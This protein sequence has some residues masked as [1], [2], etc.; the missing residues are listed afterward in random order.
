MTLPPNIEIT[1]YYYKEHVEEIS[2]ELEQAQSLGAAAAEE[3][4]K[5]LESRGKE[6]MKSSE[7]WERWELK[8]Q[9]WL[10]HQDTKRGPTA[11][12]LPSPNDFQETGSPFRHHTNTPSVHVKSQIRKYF[13]PVSGVAIKVV[14]M[15]LNKIHQSSAHRLKS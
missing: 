15:A 1:K 13:V 12:S 5:G 9:W 4:S 14:P 7:N 3:W 6:R 11:V 2:K 8:Y 10:N